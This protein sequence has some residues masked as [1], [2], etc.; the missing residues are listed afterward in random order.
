MRDSI[1]NLVRHLPVRAARLAI[2]FAF[3]GIAASH[4]Q[5]QILVDPQSRVGDVP[6]FSGTGLQ[7]YYYYDTGGGNF[8]ATIASATGPLSDRSPL[9]TFL[10]AN[11]CY[12]SCGGGGFTDSQGGL[13]AFLNGNATNIEFTGTPPGTW[14][15]SGLI[16]DGYI[17][18]TQPGSYSFSLNSDDASSFSI[19]NISGSTRGI[20]DLTFE[21]AGLYRI[22]VNFTED[23]GGS[24][25]SLTAKYDTTGDCILGCSDGQGDGVQPNGLFFSDAQI[26]GAPAPTIGS[27]GL[28]MAV[29]VLL[30]GWAVRTRWQRASELTS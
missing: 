4:V 28:S 13:T 9:A 27:G 2:V 15:N 22:A 17:A 16:L 19:G 8:D 1:V 12:P 23:G 25:L 30:A 10:S 11:V 21:L 6:A 20:N 3:V 29:L 26:E 18:I 24:L 14:N 7:G 5:A